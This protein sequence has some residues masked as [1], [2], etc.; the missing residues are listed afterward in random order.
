MKKL[1]NIKLLTLS[2][3]LLVKSR[4]TLATDSKID[5]ICSVVL[6]KPIRSP[7]YYYSNGSFNEA[8]CDYNLIWM[9]FEPPYY[10]THSIPSEYTTCVMDYIQRES[11]QYFNSGMGVFWI[12]GEDSLEKNRILK[13]HFCRTYTSSSNSCVLDC[14][15]VFEIAQCSDNYQDQVIVIEK[16]LVPSHKCDMRAFCIADI[17]KRIESKNYTVEIV[18][19]VIGSLAVIA[20]TVGIIIFAFKRRA[21]LN[22]KTPQVIVLPNPNTIDQFKSIESNHE[23]EQHTYEEPYEHYLSPLPTS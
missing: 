16:M 1:F 3:F 11:C 2:L 20:I 22:K 5:Q 21:T 6:N 17:D 12:L 19:I 13:K 8:Y 14:S 7:N 9:N 23:I 10:E 18:G 15:T 4:Y